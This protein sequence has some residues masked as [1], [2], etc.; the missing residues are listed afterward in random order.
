MNHGRPKQQKRNSKISVDS[1]VIMFTSHAWVYLFHC[2]IDFYV[3]LI[4][5]EFTK[6]ISA[7]FFFKCAI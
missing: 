2:P 4:L 3:E 7:H 6:M 1:N 5:G